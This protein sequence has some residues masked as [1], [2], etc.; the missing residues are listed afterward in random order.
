MENKI[1]IAYV[2]SFIYGYINS[3]GFI[4]M[5]GLFFTFMSGNSVRLGVHIGELKLETGFRYF[6]LFLFLIFGAFIGD[7]IFSYYR[8]TGLLILL[9]LELFLFIA[10]VLFSL[11]QNAWIVFIPLGIAM[12]IQNIV[13]LLIGNS[14]IGRSFISGIVFNLGIAFSRILQKKSE[15]GIIRIYLNTWLLFILGAVLGTIILENT[16]LCISLILITLVYVYVAVIIF[17][18]WK[19]DKRFLVKMKKNKGKFVV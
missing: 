8:K 15:W 11:K 19:S 6:S 3:L 18:I 7:L 9:V 10:S 12:G 17:R 1:K 13:N 4:I 5:N 14:L 16:N 2:F